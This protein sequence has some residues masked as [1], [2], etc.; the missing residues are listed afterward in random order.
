[1]QEA[2]SS[3]EQA[4]ES[5]RQGRTLMVFTIVT[6]FFLPASFLASLFALDIAVF[7]HAGDSLAWPNW[8]FAVIFGL[9]LAL[10]TIIIALAFYIDY[11]KKLF[12]RILD[13]YHALLPH[14]KTGVTAE[15]TQT[16][17]N[18]TAAVGDREFQLVKEYSGRTHSSL[19]RRRSD[20][21]G[22]ES[23]M[24]HKSRSIFRGGKGRDASGMISLV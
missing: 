5:I 8:A 3:R 10:S 1:M 7:P 14:N 17:P 13:L 9:T 15:G 6:I 16:E 19:G 2:M 11:L 4:Q 12:S 21:I 18:M 24:S 23:R 20:S 22:A